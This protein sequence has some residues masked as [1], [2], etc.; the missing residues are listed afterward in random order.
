[1]KA[2]FTMRRNLIGL[3]VVATAAALATAPAQAAIDSYQA[4]PL[5]AS[6]VPGPGVPGGYG[7]ALLAIDD[8]ANTVSW[9]I[10][11]LGIDLPLSGAHIHQ[12]AAGVSGGLIVHFSAQLSGSGLA[13][14]ALALITPAS[15]SGFYVNLHD[16]VHP[17]GAIRGQLGYI[18]TVA[19]PIPEPETYALM[20]AGP[21]LVVFAARRRQ[22][23]GRPVPS[24]PV[25][26]SGPNGPG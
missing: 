15:A 7:I 21:G 1:M 11:A 9:S 25:R 3:A 16:A 17:A 5:G 2:A 18:G 24:E 13:D 23:A 26:P 20:L 4:T 8:V 12:G 14:P 19:A 22:R 6:E 10:L